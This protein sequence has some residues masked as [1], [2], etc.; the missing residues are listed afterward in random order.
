[1]LYELLNS[2]TVKLAAPSEEQFGKTCFN[3]A[4]GYRIKGSY[5]HKRYS[6]HAVLGR[7]DLINTVLDFL[8]YI[9]NVSVLYSFKSSQHNRMI[10]KK[11]PLGS[12]IRKKVLQF[13]QL[14]NSQVE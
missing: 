11:L 8:A 9:Y 14:G 1:M 3:M 13:G 4:R 6:V 12:K 2:N 5:L 7:S 10:K